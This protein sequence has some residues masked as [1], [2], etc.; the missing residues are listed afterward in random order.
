MFIKDHSD[1]EGLGCRTVQGGREGGEKDMVH[2]MLLQEDTMHRFLFGTS[3]IPYELFAEIICKGSMGQQECVVSSYFSF[4]FQYI[5]VVWTTVIFGLMNQKQLPSPEH[6]FFLEHVGEL[7][8]I[9]LIDERSTTYT[10]I[11]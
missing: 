6:S 9:S 5:F 4:L 1:G 7:R 2:R 10:R 3:C 8:I 11:S